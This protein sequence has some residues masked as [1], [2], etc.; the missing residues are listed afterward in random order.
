MDTFSDGTFRPDSLV[1]REDLARLLFLNTPL[2][3]SPA[4]TPRFT[5]VFDGPNGIRVIAEAITANGSTLRDWN[6]TPKGMMSA[7]GNTFDPAG[8]TSR[9]DIAVALVRALGL[10]SEAKAKAGQLVTVSY[11]GQT[12][13]LTDNSDIPS[14]LRGYVQFALDKGILQAT[15]TLEQGPF[16][17]Q[18]T[19]KARVNPGGTN[20]RAFMAYALDHFRQH[21]VAGN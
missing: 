8:N 3:Q 11:S 4:V 20:T 9:L 6:F 14:A 2:R 10:D 16:D 13:V 19:L 17:L 15:F 12:L 5:D 21:F 7:T 1:T 18:P